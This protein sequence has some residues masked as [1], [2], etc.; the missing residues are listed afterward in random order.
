MYNVVCLLVFSIMYS[1]HPIL[2][3]GSVYSA[4]TNSI[5]H[6]TPSPLL[7]YQWKDCRY[8]H[9]AHLVANF[10]PRSCLL[11]LQG[12]NLSLQYP[13][14][15]GN[16]LL[17]VVLEN[18]KLFEAVALIERLCGR[19]RDLHMQVYCLDLLRTVRGSGTNDM[20]KAFG[21]QSARPVRLNMRS[22]WSCSALEPLGHVQLTRPWS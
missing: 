21:A 1:R 19:V 6:T 7:Q 4:C 22:A 18:P 17:V 14:I 13:R 20:L 11:R 15:V 3:H 10:C 9:P 5:G 8:P 2:A 16:E 12:G